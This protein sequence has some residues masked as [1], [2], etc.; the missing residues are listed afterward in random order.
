MDKKT[1][2]Q[3]FLASR[4]ALSAEQWQS[5]SLQICEQLSQWPPFLQAQTVL[6]YCAIAQ[7]PDLQ[8]LWQTIAPQKIW[9]F[10]RCVGRH[11]HWH[12]WQPGDPWE[13]NRYGIPEPL[14]TAAAIAPEQVDLM[15]VPAV[16][17]DRHGY[18]LGYGGGF[19]DRLLVEPSWAGVQTVGIVFAEGY[20]AQLPQD[21]WDRPLGAVCCEQGI[22][23]R[24]AA[25]RVN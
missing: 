4:Q 3:A 16:A 12:R 19:Y 13:H 24:R 2:R 18:R 5:R 21:A 17:C 20:V 9:G 6:A 11:L 14:T 15:L 23:M 25:E 10:P 22:V 8:A 7:E 1:L